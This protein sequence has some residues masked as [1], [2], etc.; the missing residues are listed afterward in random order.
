MPLPPEEA[1]KTAVHVQG[2]RSALALCHVQLSDSVMWKRTERDV[3]HM[4]NAGGARAWQ[5]AVRG[6]ARLT[7]Q[8]ALK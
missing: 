4:K 2:H 8:A 1:R 7:H 3:R 5:V 6:V